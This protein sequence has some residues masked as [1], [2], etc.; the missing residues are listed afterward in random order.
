MTRRILPMPKV[1]WLINNSSLKLVFI[2]FS[3]SVV[4]NFKYQS[5]YWSRSLSRYCS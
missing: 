5:I 3:C 1:Q 4:C 2:S